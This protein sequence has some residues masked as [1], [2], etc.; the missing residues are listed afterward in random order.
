[1]KYTGF[2]TE[3]NVFNNDTNSYKNEKFFSDDFAKSI[4]QMDEFKEKIIERLKPNF[5]EMLKENPEFAAFMKEFIDSA[6][7]L[8]EAERKE[9]LRSFSSLANSFLKSYKNNSKT[10]NKTYK[11]TTNSMDERTINNIVEGITNFM[12][13]DNNFF[14]CMTDLTKYTENLGKEDLGKFLD[15]LLKALNPLVKIAVKSL[16]NYA[17]LS[18]RQSQQAR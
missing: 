2:T 8:N 10:T 18:Y 1:M 12:H 11:K 9:V 5:R 16:V 7:N 17:V 6:K 15:G 3:K 4:G 13:S 14:K